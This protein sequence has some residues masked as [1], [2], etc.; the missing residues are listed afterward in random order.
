M[1][2]ARLHGSRF[3]IF[4]SGSSGACPRICPGIRFGF[5]VALLVFALL[6]LRTSPSPVCAQVNEWTDI[7][8]IVKVS[9]LLDGEEL[10]STGVVFR[11]EKGKAYIR[12]GKAFTRPN[13]RQTSRTQQL[14]NANR[15][16]RI[17]LRPGS[18]QSTIVP[19]ELVVGSRFTGSGEILVADAKLCPP[20]L[21]LTK[22]TEFT[23]GDKL[24][25]IT[26]EHRTIKSMIA[27]RRIEG[28]ATI[29][30]V[31]LFSNGIV[32]K[33]EA[34]IVSEDF[35]S[36]A[37]IT[38]SEG[39][40]FGSLIDLRKTTLPKTERHYAV[41]SNTNAI[42]LPSA[43][44]TFFTTRP[45]YRHVEMRGD[46][47]KIKLF[48]GLTPILDKPVRLSIKYEVFSGSGRTPNHLTENAKLVELKRMS[49]DRWGE[50]EGG[51]AEGPGA[52]RTRLVK[53]N[54]DYP[55]KEIWA[56]D[57]T[58]TIKRNRPGSHTLYTVVYRLIET[59][60]DGSVVQGR[61]RVSQYH[62]NLY[63]RK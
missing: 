62:P 37:F 19:A 21:A 44:K 50:L 48:V 14:N 45:S 54:F 55:F 7:D 9:S 15:Q 39:Q 29:Q 18:F 27:I 6:T 40:F 26:F 41:Y 63:K 51:F 47:A 56:G 60:E 8:S 25:F 49:P 11:V 22:I 32:H 42:G 31:E 38:N 2:A 17:I 36:L 58:A 5:R 20:P 24:Q 61:R 33:V 3:S 57:I 13:S 34:S 23:E 43:S 4:Q 12:A 46:V 1:N 52:A 28:E 59:R 30:K 10:V 53:E 35:L 16:W